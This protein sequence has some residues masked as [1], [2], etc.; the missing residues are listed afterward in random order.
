MSF[1]KRKCPSCSD[2]NFSL[3]YLNSH[4]GNRKLPVILINGTATTIK[5][6]RSS[7]TCVVVVKMD[8]VNMSAS[9][10]IFLAYRYKSQGNRLLRNHSKYILHSLISEQSRRFWFGKAPADLAFQVFRNFL[11]CRLS[12]FPKLPL[13]YGSSKL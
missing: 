1:F 4:F 8:R 2:G 5:K 10:N 3:R 7:L 12:V 11:S 6:W 13:I 9:C